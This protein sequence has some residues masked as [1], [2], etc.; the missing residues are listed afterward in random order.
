M[1]PLF[2][3]A[4]YFELGFDDTV[5]VISCTWRTTTI[6]TSM[7]R[8]TDTRRGF[9]FLTRQTPPRLSFVLKH[10]KFIQI[11]KLGLRGLHMK[12]IFFTD[13][14]TL[15][16]EVYAWHAFLTGGRTIECANECL[17]LCRPIRLPYMCCLSR[18]LARAAGLANPSHLG[19]DDGAWVS[20]DVTVR[21][22]NYYCWWKKPC[23]SWG[24]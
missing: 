21:D 15:K 14:K 17:M 6:R 5:R 13:E 18:L 22:C 24:W 12:G 4:K 7:L 19:G 16:P 20:R 9:N 11:G 23:T 2:S 10:G 8:A 1:I 3:I